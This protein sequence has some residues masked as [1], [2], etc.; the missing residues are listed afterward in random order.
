MLA[1][2]KAQ[3]ENTILER[4]GFRVEFELFDGKRPTLPPYDYPV[5]ASQRWKAAVVKN[6]PN[7]RKVTQ[8]AVGWNRRR[9]QR[10][11]LE[12]AD[13]PSRRESD[14]G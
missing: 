13:V 7:G 6:S 1:S 8:L 5:M 12:A 2:S 3:V 14:G 4:E 10:G 11:R 9:Q